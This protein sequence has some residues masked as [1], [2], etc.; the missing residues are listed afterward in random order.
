MDICMIRDKII[1]WVSFKWNII[2]TIKEKV[3]KIKLITISY[4]NGI[5]KVPNP[6][7][8][9]GYQLTRSA[10]VDYRKDATFHIYFC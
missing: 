2:P 9:A 10:Q 3:K 4:L 5:G 7:L 8:S 1:V 6:K